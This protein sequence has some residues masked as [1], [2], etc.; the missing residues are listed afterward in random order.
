[1]NISRRMRTSPLSYILTAHPLFIVTLFLLCI[2]SFFFTPHAKAQEPLTPSQTNTQKT[3]PLSKEDKQVLF[4]NSYHRGDRWSDDVESGLREIISISPKKINLSVAYLDTLRHVNPAI[5]ENIA[6]IFVL[7]NLGQSTDL[8]VVSDEAAFDFVLANKNQ[9]FKNQPIIYASLSDVSSYPPSSILNTTGISKNTDY[10]TGIELALSLHPK[11]KSIVFVGSQTQGE[12]SNVI[13]YVN[14]NIVPLFEKNY[15]VKI[16]PEIPLHELDK[17]LS[18]LPANSLIFALNN[19]L[20]NKDESTL[21]PAET[22]RF[23]SSV[24]PYPVYTFWNS[25]LGHGVVGG[26]ILTGYSQGKAAGQLALQVLENE[27]AIPLPLPK[28]TPNSFFFDL[29]MIDKFNIDKSLLPE[30]SRFI[31]EQKPIWEEYKI[32]VLMT[33]ALLFGLIS[34]VLSFIL[35]SKRQ[36]ETIVQINDENIELNHALDLNQG[37]LEDMTQH[38]EEITTL[39]ELT[40]LSNERYFNDMLSKELRRA[41]RHKNPVTLLL[42]SFDHYSSYLHHFGDAIT[43]KHIR[44]IAQIIAQTCQRSSDLL[45]YFDNGEFAIL[46]PHTNK[47][48]ALVVSQKLHDNLLD[49]HFFSVVQKNKPITFSIGLSSLEDGNIQIEPQ[50]MLLASKR[51]RLEAIK[52]GG[53]ITCS[54]II[55]A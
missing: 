39:D 38:L 28:S 54:E 37:S 43:R 33:I 17:M 2:F 8:I 21:S 48:N 14:E 9:I 27:R 6:D 52:Q 16:I 22:A 4:I 25:H 5:L 46:L 19:T 55:K 26:L 32:E 1:M 31:N 47:N 41:T 3:A 24:S 34:I 13:Q 10:L 20:N 23:L 49:T 15:D 45:A 53:N 11:T 7:K 12:N 44:Q 35:L 50:T 29:E 18:D 51:L 36:T 40:G 42:L 30:G